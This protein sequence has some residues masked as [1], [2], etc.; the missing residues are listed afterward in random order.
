MPALESGEALLK[1]F[2]WQVFGMEVVGEATDV[3][4]F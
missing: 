2:L 3:E 4:V 1:F